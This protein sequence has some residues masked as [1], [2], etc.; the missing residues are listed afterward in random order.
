M[1]LGVN[2]YIYVH[3]LGALVSRDFAVAD[4]LTCLMLFIYL[5]RICFC[6]S[7]VSHLHDELA[8]ADY[9]YL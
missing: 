7:R 2:Y 1:P 8:I 6:T 9:V 5:V 4:A 3:S